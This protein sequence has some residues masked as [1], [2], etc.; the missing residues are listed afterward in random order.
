MASKHK[1][2]SVDIKLQA[3]DKVDKKGK[4]KIQI[5]KK[6]MVFHVAHCQVSNSLIQRNSVLLQICSFKIIKENEEIKDYLNCCL[7]SASQQD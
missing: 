6:N 4:S 1:P 5:A 7:S 3:F 2:V